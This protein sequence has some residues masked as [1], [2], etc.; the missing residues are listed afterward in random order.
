MSHFGDTYHATGNTAAAREAWQQ[1]LTI[2]DQLGHS[3]AEQVRAKLAT[4]DTGPGES[5]TED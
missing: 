1:A 4:L 5:T 2:F 3:D